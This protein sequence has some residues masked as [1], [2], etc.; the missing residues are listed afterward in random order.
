MLLP[1]WLNYCTI[2]GGT[3]DER[4]VWS[5]NKILRDACYRGVL[6]K[7]VAR[8]R[9]YNLSLT[10]KVCNNSKLCKE[11]NL[12]NYCFLSKPEI[13]N[14]LRQ[15]TKLYKFQYSICN[16]TFRNVKCYVIKIN[17]TATRAIATVVLQSIKKLYEFPQN[18]YLSQAFKMQHLPAFR[19]DN[20]Q[21]LFMAVASCYE[22][23]GA[24]DHVFGICRKFMTIS[25]M[26]ARLP[27]IA[28]ACEL[29]KDYRSNYNLKT[30]DLPLYSTDLI[31]D[32]TY[33]NTHLENYVQ[34]Y[35]QLKTR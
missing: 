7:M 11:D 23:E 9:K 5:G 12:N 13:F 27:R 17:I 21:N 32:N 18:F 14:Y 30:L 26:K 1:K 4:P 34:N 22:Y 25:Q 24:R 3:I 33:F 29:Y 10:I 16:G 8:D 6:T 28:Y 20:I 19:F 31:L 35:H 2:F 15:L